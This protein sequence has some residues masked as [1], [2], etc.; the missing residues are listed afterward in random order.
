[1]LHHQLEPLAQLGGALLGGQRT[2]GRQRLVGGLDG[3]AGFGGAHLRHA[4]EN[5]ASGRVVD[6]DGLAAV[7]VLPGAVDVG[8]LAEQRGVFQL[9]V[10]LLNPVL[11]NEQ[12]RGKPRH[13]ATRYRSCS[14]TRRGRSR[15][16]NREPRGPLEFP[17]GDSRA[18]EISNES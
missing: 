15:R 6:L 11:G 3:A 7:G 5:F 9:H 2:P 10:S 1:M 8:L 12:K 18:F 16:S 13:A 14:V 17:A 4:A